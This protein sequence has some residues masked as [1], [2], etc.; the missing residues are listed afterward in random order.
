[1]KPIERF[2]AKAT[3]VA[4]YV[5]LFAMPITGLDDVLRQELLR[6]L[7]PGLFTWPN[8]IQ[9]SDDAFIFLRDTA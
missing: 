7:V 1:M 8:L 2:L 4:F 6:E 9:Q 3:H 5:L